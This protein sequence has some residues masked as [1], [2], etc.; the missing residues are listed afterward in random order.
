MPLWVLRRVSFLG[1]WPPPVG[2]AVGQKGFEIF[3]TV[4]RE[5]CNLLAVGVIPDEALNLIHP[6]ADLP[7]EVFGD[8]GNDFHVMWIA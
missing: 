4:I 8:K 1:I 3:N 7:D 5:G 2:V 6:V